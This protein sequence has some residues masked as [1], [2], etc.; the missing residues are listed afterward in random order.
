MTQSLQSAILNGCPDT[1]PGSFVNFDESLYYCSGGLEKD[2][3]QNIEI[4]E[5]I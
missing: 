2:E 1:D 3:I 5:S 4:H